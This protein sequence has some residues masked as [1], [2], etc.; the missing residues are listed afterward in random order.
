[1]VIIGLYIAWTLHKILYLCIKL[2]LL[3]REK[4]TTIKNTRR[5]IMK[6]PIPQLLILAILVLCFPSFIK[7]NPINIKPSRSINFIVYLGKKI[8]WS[9]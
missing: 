8:K 2:S 9:L 1:M 7:N 6:K 4:M 3:I 5:F